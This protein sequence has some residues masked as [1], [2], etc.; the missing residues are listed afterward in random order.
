MAA[1]TQLRHLSLSSPVEDIRLTASYRA[2]I[3]SMPAL[4]TV[5]VL[6]PADISQQAWDAALAQM[7]K[8]RRLRSHPKIS[9]V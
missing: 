3:S 9:L 6:K 4:E 2:V 8:Y 7:R 1:A 5:S